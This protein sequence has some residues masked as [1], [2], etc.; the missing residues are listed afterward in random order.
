[1]TEFKIPCPI[2]STKAFEKEK[3]EAYRQKVRV[4]FGKA[5][6]DA[7]R[8]LDDCEELLDEVDPEEIPFLQTFNSWRKYKDLRQLALAPR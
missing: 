4:Y 5:E 7:C 8:T 6:Y 3:L 1:M 2:P